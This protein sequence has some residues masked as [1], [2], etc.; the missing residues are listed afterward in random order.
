MTVPSAYSFTRYL[1]AKKSVD[2]RSLNRMVWD[3]LARAVAAY[4]QGDRLD[5]LEIG[6][7]IGT[8]I[9][10]TL[11]WGLLTRA[12]YV[13]LDA[14]QALISDARSRLTSW[15]AAKGYSVETR[16]RDS[17]RLQ[18][19]DQDVQV[20]LKVADIFDFVSRAEGDSSWDLLIAHAFLDL[21]DVPST[22]PLLLS[23][24][25]P[26]GLFYFT[27]TFDGATIL[28]PEIDP[29]FD[30]QIEILYHETMDRRIIRGKPSGDSRTGRHFFEQVSSAGASMLEAGASDW[31]VFAGP[32]G[33][34]ADE[35]YFLHF[36]IHTI[37]SGLGNHPAIDQERLAWWVSERH[38]QVEE[39]RLVYIAHQMDFLGCASEPLGFE[40]RF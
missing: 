21:V 23:V 9:E 7:G 36:I 35:A 30:A 38:R 11:D 6:V 10:R 26:R 20:E 27:I 37:G 13:A 16:S 22:L 14:E 8:M 18:R 31:V 12:K 3:S 39:K 33:Y 24:L 2:D 40:N 34:R 5:V 32:S 1:A 17:I 4:P 19:K 15:G 29:P 25:K 28:Q